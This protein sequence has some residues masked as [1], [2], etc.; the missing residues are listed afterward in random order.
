MIGYK[1]IAA[2]LDKNNEEVILH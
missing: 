2:N 1:V